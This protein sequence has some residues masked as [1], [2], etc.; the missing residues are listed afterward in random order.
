MKIDRSHYLQE[1]AVVEAGLLLQL[2][3]PTHHMDQLQAAAADLA[4]ITRQLHSDNGTAGDSSLAARISIALAPCEPCEH[5]QPPYGGQPTFGL[6]GARVVACEACASRP[7]PRHPDTI[8]TCEWCG[9]E[10][11]GW[12]EIHAATGGVYATGMACLAC[13]QELG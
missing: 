11:D 7:W 10:A 6:L 8:T 1:L 3:A 12:A 13:H 9:C 5:L 4:S 2:P